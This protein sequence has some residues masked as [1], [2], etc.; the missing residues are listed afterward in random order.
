[1][2]KIFHIETSETKR[3]NKSPDTGP[4]LAYKLQSEWKAGE[5]GDNVRAYANY[6]LF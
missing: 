4:L 2:T 3:Q 5:F 1:M 6:S